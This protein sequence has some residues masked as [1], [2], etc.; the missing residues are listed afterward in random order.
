MKGKGGTTLS[1]RKED[2]PYGSADQS[3]DDPEGR[4]DPGKQAGDLGNSKTMEN[5]VLYT[6]F[7]D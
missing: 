2:T 3:G 4:E 5:R 7:E 1:V 6:T